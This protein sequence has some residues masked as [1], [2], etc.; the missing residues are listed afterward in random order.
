LAKHY[1]LTGGAGF[2][3]SRVAAQLLD[4]GHRVTAIDEMNDA[5]DVRLKEW[6]LKQL[7]GRPNLAF[8]RLDIRDRAA[9]RP[10][11]KKKVDAVIN[12]AARAG[13]RQS[14]ANPWVY[15]ETNT[16]GALNLLELSK[17]F[18][19]SKYV[20]SSTSSVYGAK[21]KIPFKEDAN[22]NYPI[23]PYAASKKA[24]EALCYTYH[25][26]FKIDVTVLRYFTVYGPGGR[27]DMSLFRFTQ[28]IAEG[29][30]VVVFGDGRQ[31]RDFTYV[32]D[33]ARGTIAALRPVGFD[34]INLGSDRPVTVNKA[35][36]LIES[37]L[38][39]KAVIERQPMHPA[40]IR[41]TWADISKARRVLKW[42]PKT[43][44][45]QGVAALVDW[46]LENRAWAKQ[47]ATG[48]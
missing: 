39:K 24:A 18:G 17:E 40:D 34:T 42:E 25:Y 37:R 21:N 32:D 48:G 13:V 26:L 10:I 8:H 15:F 20:L 44:F 31:S 45:E 23:S 36:R 41:A 27:P 33:V 5:Y 2:I 12:L 22:T 47:I 16:T 35:I 7:V 4:A 46:Y 19:V 1:L 30:P 6:R 38:E 29:K 14:I 9:L 11:F 28:W 43:T 3:G